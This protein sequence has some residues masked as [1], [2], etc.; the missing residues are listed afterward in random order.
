MPPIKVFRVEA[1]TDTTEAS[2]EKVEEEI[3]A[4]YTD[5]IARNGTILDSHVLSVIRNQG[6]EARIVAES[7][8]IVADIP[9]AQT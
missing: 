1:P 6:R 5:V 7:L 4:I 3:K 8:Y 9:E 2:S